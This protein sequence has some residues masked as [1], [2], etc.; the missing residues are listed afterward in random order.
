MRRPET[1]ANQFASSL[2]G[3][4]TII[5]AGVEPVDCDPV[6]MAKTA[7]EELAKTATLVVQ[8]FNKGLFKEAEVLLPDARDNAFNVIAERIA[9]YVATPP[10]AD[11]DGTMYLTRK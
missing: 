1:V 8:K 6:A 7:A 10:P 9:E 3:G 4:Q 5:H 2:D 11:F